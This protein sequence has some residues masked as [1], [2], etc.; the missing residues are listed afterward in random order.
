MFEKIKNCFF[1]LIL[2][3]LILITSCNSSAYAMDIRDNKVWVPTQCV[4]K[5][6]EDNL[7]RS[8]KYSYISTLIQ[9]VCP[10]GSYKED[11]YTRCVVQLYSHSSRYL[12]LSDEY[13][14]SEGSGNNKIYMSEGYL[15]RETVDFY[16]KG[17]NPKYD[18]YVSYYCN[19]N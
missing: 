1:S 17:N 13:V 16:I 4:Y 2:L 18:A 12:P 11:N 8:C 14:L 5:L 9:S 19:G 3:S 15:D 6:A 10:T 7:E